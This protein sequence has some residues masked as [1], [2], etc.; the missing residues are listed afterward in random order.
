MKPW[1]SIKNS[2]TGT[3]ELE[4]FDEIGPWGVTAKD[5]S[6]DL[7][8]VTSDEINVSINTI[9][10]DVFAGLG[11]FNLLK[12]SGKKINVKIGGIAASIGS[13]IAMAGD[14]IRMPSNTFMMVHNPWTFAMGNSDELRETADVLDKIGASLTGIYVKRTGKTEDEIKALLAK[15]TYL[16]AAECVE[17]GFADEVTEEVSASAKFDLSDLPENVRAVFASARKSKVRGPEDD[18]QDPADDDNDD[19]SIGKLE[20]L[21]VKHGVSDYVA[22]L[23]LDEKAIANPS[24]AVAEVREIVALCKAV[25]SDKAKEFVAARKTITEA[26]AALVEARADQDDAS[27]TSSKRK[28]QDHRAGSGVKANIN[29]IYAKFTGVKKG[30]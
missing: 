14:K 22:I 23:A 1:Y 28:T 25:G 2:T 26:R 19:T 24:A 10:G 6:R 3:T 15:D 5:F 9:G 21:A 17:M 29:D 8:A 4:I 18:E 11:I 13:V 27:H 30:K 12:A 16:S 7:K 20:A